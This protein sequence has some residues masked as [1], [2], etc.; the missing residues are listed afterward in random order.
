MAPGM[1][2]A[3]FNAQ[4]PHCSIHRFNILTSCYSAN[5][6]TSTQEVFTA[7]LARL[8]KALLLL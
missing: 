1:V 6:A 7:W 8:E 5:S 4:A 2:E 3:Q